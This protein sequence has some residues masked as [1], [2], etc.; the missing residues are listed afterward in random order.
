[1]CDDMQVAVVHGVMQGL[2][3]RSRRQRECQVARGGSRLMSKA[4]NERW[5]NWIRLPEL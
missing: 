1:V 2:H 5:G 4:A 3:R